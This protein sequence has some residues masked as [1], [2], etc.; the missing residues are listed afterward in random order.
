MEIDVII[1]GALFIIGGIAFIGFGVYNRWFRSYIPNPK[2]WGRVRAKVIGRHHYTE[3]NISK[4]S[5]YAFTDHYEK[6]IAYTVDGKTYKKY[7]D[8]T[9]NGS[10]HIWYRLNNPNVIRTMSEVRRSKWEGKSKVSLGGNI[11]FGAAMLIIG[12]AIIYGGFM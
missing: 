2:K 9:E 8:D 11:F 7:V 6:C 4:Y 12:I 3:K 10:V 5:G 1:I